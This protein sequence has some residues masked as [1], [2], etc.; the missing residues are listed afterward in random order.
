MNG[1]LFTRPARPGKCRRPTLEALEDRT[2]LSPVDFIEVQSLSPLT[3][4]GTI[5]G[6]AIQPHQVR[7]SN[8]Y[9]IMA[10]LRRQGFQRVADDHLRDD[11]LELKR[12]LKFHLETHD[13]L[14]LTG[15]VSMGKMDFVPRVLDE[16]VPR[17]NDGQH[18][19]T[20][21]PDAGHSRGGGNCDLGRL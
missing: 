1:S 12:R 20:A 6:A 15:G 18:G 3:L 5:A 14:V 19:L 8:V 16:L 4:S 21:D 17:R 9:A 13:V 11:F 2:V 10:A 7:R